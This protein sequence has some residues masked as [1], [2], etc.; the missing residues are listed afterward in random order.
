MTN[1]E[2][3]EERE[4]V[5]GNLW[6]AKS[7]CHRTDPRSMNHVQGRPRGAGRRKFILSTSQVSKEASGRLGLPSWVSHILGCSG[8]PST[9]S[10]SNTRYILSPPPLATA[11]WSFHLSL[12]AADHLSRG[13]PGL[14]SRPLWSH[15]LTSHSSPYNPMDPTKWKAGKKKN[16]QN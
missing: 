2:R 9:Q 4:V 16:K 15:G 5:T 10:F 1:W 13:M 14:T 8:N 11:Q 12:G 7:W 3:K 6:R